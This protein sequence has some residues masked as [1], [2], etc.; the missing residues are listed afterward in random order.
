MSRRALNR[1]SREWKVKR[2]LQRNWRRNCGRQLMAEKGGKC[3]LVGAG[4]GDLGLV[5]LRAKECIEQSEVI[6][7]DYLCNTEMLRSAPESAELIFAGKKAGA[8]TLTQEQINALLVDK[9]REGKNVV[10]LKGGDP[11]LFG[12]GGE[13]ARALAAAK[14]PFVI[15]PGVSS[16]IA[17]PA[18][19][20]IPV[21]HRGNNSH[22]TFFTGHE[23][24]GKDESAIDFSALAK[25]GGA[26]VM[27]M[28]VE[29]IG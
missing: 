20:G 8:H 13:E 17:G 16:A 11:F 12:R 23:D 22:V 21:T 4:P 29:R 9:T 6:V 25:L 7:Y 10:R 24:P 15:V 19:A 28:G 18:Y 26:Q 1:A 2:W 5:T 3:F 14:L 27:L